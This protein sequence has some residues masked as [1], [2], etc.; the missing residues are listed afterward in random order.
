MIHILKRLV[1]VALAA[2]LALAA[3][4]WISAAA[5]GPDAAAAG[6]GQSA[7]TATKL[8]LSADHVFSLGVLASLVRKQAGTEFYVEKPYQA[9]RL[10]VSAG[11]YE[12]PDLVAALE[13]AT[14]LQVRKLANMQLLTSPN[15]A[16]EANGLPF[17]PPAPLMA[18][19]LHN[20]QPLDES[21]NLRKEGVPFNTGWFLNAKQARFRDLSPD[22]QSFIRKAVEM[23]GA[24]SDEYPVDDS[25]EAIRK[26]NRALGPSTIR[27]GASYL[28]GFEVY[29]PT[30]SPQGQDMA[31]YL[32]YFQ[33]AYDYAD[34]LRASP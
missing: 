18:R 4:F 19:L 13:V 16:R 27:F 33:V 34:Q 25:P 24:T 30:K 6:S 5:R 31:N 20:L 2:F 12:A 29:T 10:F 26:R 7:H 32:S 3:A 21:V 23:A 1:P 14:G 22:Q 15:A 9:R 28:L 11:T 17:I 8:V